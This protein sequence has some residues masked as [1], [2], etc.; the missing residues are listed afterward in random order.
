MTD[1]CP[2]VPVTQG[3]LEKW[4]HP[5]QKSPERGSGDLGVGHTGLARERAPALPGVGTGPS[6]LAPGAPGFHLGAGLSLSFS[7]KFTPRLWS[8]PLLSHRIANFQQAGWNCYQGGHPSPYTHAPHPQGFPAGP[9][10]PYLSVA[11]VLFSSAHPCTGGS[12]SKESACNTG[13]P[14]SIPGS[15]RSP[16]KGMATCLENPMDRGA[17]RATAQGVTRVGHA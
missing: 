6:D 5:W 11:T 10:P 1:A 7:G 15:G 2:Q 9:G 17:W 16:K 12:D 8:S 3:W 4:S 13:D 14:G